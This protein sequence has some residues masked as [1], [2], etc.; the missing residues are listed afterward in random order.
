M[1]E[2]QEAEVAKRLTE[3]D[4]WKWAKTKLDSMIEAYLHS[5]LT[6][7]DTAVGRE[8]KRRKDVAATII[9]WIEYIE[10]TAPIPKFLEETKFIK[11][12]QVT[13]EL[14]QPSPK[15]F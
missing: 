10:G 8:Y 7:T 3:N 11:R 5:A 1:T 13:A 14:F 2:D 12:F 4:D 9:S 15:L 6:G